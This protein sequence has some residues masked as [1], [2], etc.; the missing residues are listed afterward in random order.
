MWVLFCIIVKWFFV[1]INDRIFDFVEFKLVKFYFLKNFFIKLFILFVVENMKLKLK[2]LI[3]E[4]VNVVS[5]EWKFVFDFLF[6]FLIYI[7]WEMIVMLF[8]VFLLYNLIGRDMVW[9]CSY[10]EMECY[11]GKN[12][13]KV[14]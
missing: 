4:N 7:V 5:M 8:S 14:G 12:E 2:I 11:F 1:I 6:G 9:K 13:K 10:F 3:E